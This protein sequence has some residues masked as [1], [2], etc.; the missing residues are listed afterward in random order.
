MKIVA[1]WPLGAILVFSS[2]HSA[3]CHGYLLEPPSRSS[4][5]RVGFPTPKNWNDNSLFC[6]G[7]A[8]QYS[9]Q[10]GKCGICGD[11]YQGPRENEAGGTYATG[12]ISRKYTQGQI[13]DATVVVTANHLGW[14]EF[15]ICPNNNPEKAATHD[16]LN[17]HV[18]QLADGS[19]SKLYIGTTV[20]AIHVKLRL[21]ADVTCTQ[22]VLQWRWPVGNNF[23]DCPDG[24]HKLGCGPQEEFYGCSDVEITPTTG[25][26]PSATQANSGHRMTTLGLHSHTTTTPHRNPRTPQ[27]TQQAF[28]VFGRPANGGSSIG[29][30]GS[31][32]GQ[33]ESV[34]GQG[35]QCRA[36]S[37]MWRG[38]PAMDAWCQSNC[39][40]FNCPSAQC[41][42]N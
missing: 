5:W 33:T 13:I 10:G 30:S 12:T 26:Q 22:C 38:Q 21:P 40:A 24:T 37:P 41:A 17:R 34:I 39:A 11:P 3:S 29:H 4:M 36:I 16:C 19:G 14:F 8:N 42:C 25:Q 2:F 20:G 23:G 32:I 35:V 31:S 18:L 1:S 15:K 9:A 27:N 6:G 28:H 7:Y